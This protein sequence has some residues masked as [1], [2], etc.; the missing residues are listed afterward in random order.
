MKTSLTAPRWCAIV[1]LLRKKRNASSLFILNIHSQPS[2][3]KDLFQR[4]FALAL[5]L[6]KQNL[7]VLGDFNAT[8]P[9]WG[10]SQATTK[11]AKLHDA[12]CQHQFSLL[13]G[14][15]LMTRTGIAKIGTRGT[16]S[17]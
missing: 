6:A 8:Y 11:G 16:T 4:L 15:K 3:T 7:L 13:T 12:I 14:T 9:S 17:R 2:R 10:Y 5:H 1:K